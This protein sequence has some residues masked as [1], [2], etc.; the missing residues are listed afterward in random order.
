[1]R[2]TAAAAVLLAHASA[3]S[4]QVFSYEADS[5]PENGGWDIAQIWCDPT[6]TLDD[7]LFVQ[8][9]DLCPGFDPPGGQEGAYKRSVA[10]FLGT[11]VFFVEWRLETDGEASELI[12]GGA[13][14]FSVW[15]TGPVDY[16][17]TITKD[18]AWLNRDFP[19]DVIDVTLPLGPEGEPLP[20]TH[21]LELYGDEW[22]IWYIDGLPVFAD[23]PEGDY[24]ALDAY[25]PS[26][27]WRAKA[28]W[29]PNVTNWDFIRYGV[30]PEPA[31][32]D[33]DSSETVDLFDWYFVQDCLSKDG[34]GIYGG[35]GS[36]C[37]DDDETCEAIGE[38]TTAGPGCTFADF[39]GDADVDLRDVA[40]F[41]TAFNPVE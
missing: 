14:S 30:I 6:L 3:C 20:H 21:R 16:A 38:T 37:P 1:M 25:V 32:S 13:A 18:E 17:Y 35:P 4:G 22:F 31:S 19:F 33:Y 5:L 10:D 36:P 40:D 29:L 9:V 15:S 23:V 7:G 27:T 39:D 26:I 2:A 41:L 28:A 12:W 24:L 8:V 11:P 34:I